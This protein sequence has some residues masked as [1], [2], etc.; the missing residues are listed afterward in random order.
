[1]KK[2]KVLSITFQGSANT[3]IDSL[4]MLLLKKPKKK[5]RFKFR[6]HLKSTSEAEI[7]FMHI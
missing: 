2:I 7:L 3:D 5:N 6:T 4:A 1:M